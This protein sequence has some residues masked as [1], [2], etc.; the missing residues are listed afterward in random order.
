L[1]KAI[2]F[3]QKCVQLLPRA[4]LVTK[5]DSMRTRKANPRYR[6]TVF[7]ALAGL[8]TIILTSYSPLSLATSEVRKPAPHSDKV[9][10]VATSQSKSSFPDRLMPVDANHAAVSSSKSHIGRGAL[11]QSCTISV[12]PFGAIFSNSGGSGFLSMLTQSP[13]LLT[14]VNAASFADKVAS[15]SIVA[16]FGANLATMTQSAQSNPLPTTLANRMVRVRDSAGIARFA[17][18]FFVSPNQINYLMPV[19]TANGLAT[20]EVIP[21]GG[22]SVIASGGAQ[23]TSVAPGIFTVSGTGSPPTAVGQ[24]LRYSG[25]V[26][27]DSGSLETPIAFGDPGDKV[28]LVLY[29]ADIRGRSSLSAV[30][31][32][33]GGSSAVVEYAGPQGEFEGLDQL[34]VLLA[35]GFVGLEQLIVVVTV[36]GVAANTV[37]V[38]A[39][40]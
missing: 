19:G 24:W 25:G 27:V 13:G 4:S 6:L 14:S 36:D 37:K 33:V 26:L 31:A 9:G 16:G 22:G 11:A 7:I 3:N 8:L 28:Y 5:E 23:V 15:D 35:P 32:N 17:T 21:Q 38:T 12:S 18:L 30:S 2:A 40:K 10:A 39:G 29:G 1:E 20:V 34:N